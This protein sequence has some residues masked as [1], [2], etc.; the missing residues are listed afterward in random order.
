MHILRHF[1]ASHKIWPYDAH[2]RAYGQV[3]P[4]HPSPSSGMA[5]SFRR[6]SS[7]EWRSRYSQ[8]RTPMGI[9]S[10]RIST[11]AEIYQQY[12]NDNQT[13]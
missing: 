5:A 13:P 4:A 11:R 10:V 1:V 9:L 6:T 8:P 12:Q 3:C 2:S 7:P